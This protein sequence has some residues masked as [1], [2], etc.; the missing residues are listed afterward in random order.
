MK[1]T[2]LLM[3]TLRLILLSGMAFGIA[4]NVHAQSSAGGAA[5]SNAGA[6]TAGGGAGQ[7]GGGVPIQSGTISGFDYDSSTS[8][9][10]KT[11]Q[12]S[13]AGKQGGSAAGQGAPNKKGSST[14]PHRKPGSGSSAQ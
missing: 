8:G 14:E 13:S 10:L 6:G 4:T 7:P 2:S 9:E 1:N 12:G 5:G 11:G 3:K